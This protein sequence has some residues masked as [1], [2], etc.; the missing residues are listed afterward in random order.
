MKEKAW[1]LTWVIPILMTVGGIA[2]IIWPAESLRAVYYVLGFALIA[3]GAVGLVLL[4]KAETGKEKLHGFK[5][6]LL[7]LIG[8]VV[9]INPAPFEAILPILIGCVFIGIG[10][11]NLVRAISLRSLVIGKILLVIA[12]LSLVF[13]GLIVWNPCNSTGVLAVILGLGLSCAGIAMLAGSR[14]LKMAEIN[15]D[16]GEQPS[17]FKDAVFEES[18]EDIAGEA[19]AKFGDAEVSD[20]FATADVAES[21]DDMDLATAVKLAQAEEADA[22]DVDE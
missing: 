13:G 5:Y 10:A 9:M 3:A 1:I 2:V 8:A 19:A 16:V 18:P 21:V 12:L 22:V 14:K 20:G 15:I 4:V 6:F 17:S 11:I 7:V